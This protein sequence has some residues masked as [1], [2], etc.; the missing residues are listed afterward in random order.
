MHTKRFQSVLSY[1]DK[2]FYFSFC[3]VG[4]VIFLVFLFVGRYLL[5]SV[6]SVY[7]FSS[8]IVSSY[9]ESRCI[10]RVKQTAVSHPLLSMHMDVCSHS[11]L[12]PLS[13]D[14]KIKNNDVTH[15]NHIKKTKKKKERK[16]ERM[17]GRKKA[18]IS[19]HS[20]STLFLSQPVYG[21]PAFRFFLASFHSDVFFLGFFYFSLSFF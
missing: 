1:N 6:F 20:P 2:R 9:V 14:G 8:F 7:S 11:F 18:I 13:V 3:L 5:Y 19:E 15:V 12:S 4:L 17:K 16:K 21:S 10:Y